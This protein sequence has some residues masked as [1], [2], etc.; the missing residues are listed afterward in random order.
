[1][2]T[3]PATA[4]VVSKSARQ[5]TNYTAPL[6]VLT[7]LFFIWGAITSLNDI[8]IPHLKGV[9]D[10]NYTQTMLIQFTFFTAYFLVSLPSGMIVDRIGYKRGIVIG[11]ITAGIGCLM[12]YPAA[13][14]R[15]YP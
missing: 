5:D 13:A 14:V 6:I 15:S 9:F 12:F 1:M 10:L 7:S 4:T 8:L 3:A 2:A 11:L